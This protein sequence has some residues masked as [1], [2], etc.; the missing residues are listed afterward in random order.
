M[1]MRIRPIFKVDGYDYTFETP[2][3]GLPKGSN[4]E[5]RYIIDTLRKYLGDDL[6]FTEE[7]GLFLLPYTAED[8]DIVTKINS[9][10]EYYPIKYGR[11][12]LWFE[13]V[14]MCK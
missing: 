8:L 12:Y 6:Y 2:Q 4:A 11:S 9:D 14:E 13:I 7:Y 10:T 3:P 1:T 5:Y